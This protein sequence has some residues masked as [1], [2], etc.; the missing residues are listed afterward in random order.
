MV[1]TFWVIKVTKVERKYHLRQVRRG[2]S[3]GVGYSIA[4][5]ERH[6]AEG[7]EHGAWGIESKDRGQ[8]SEVRGW[9]IEVRS[10]MLLWKRLSAAIFMDNE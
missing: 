5:L 7:M 2:L 6:G 1:A 4:D 3:E 9:R 10:Q 8:K